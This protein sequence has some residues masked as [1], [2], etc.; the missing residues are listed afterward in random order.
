MTTEEAIAILKNPKSMMSDVIDAQD[1]AI[2][3]LEKQTPKKPVWQAY[4]CCPMCKAQVFYILRNY[5]YCPNCGQA[6]DWSEE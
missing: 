6:L 3:A 4:N 2:E 5:N 1:I